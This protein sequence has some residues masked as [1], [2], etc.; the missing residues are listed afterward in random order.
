M[1]WAIRYTKSANKEL[2]KLDKQVAKRIVDYMD[3]HIAP[4]DDAR[5]VGKILTGPLGEYWRY[6][7]GDY[8]VICAIQDAELVVLVVRI[9]KRSDVYD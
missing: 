8:R 1:V 6:R 3:K 7:V 4:L 9:G 2:G 5:S